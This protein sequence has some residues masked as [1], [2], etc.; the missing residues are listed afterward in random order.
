MLVPCP[1]I[2]LANYALT[3]V[4][5]CLVP[6]HNQDYIYANMSPVEDMMMMCF[7]CEGQLENQNTNFF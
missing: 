5:N 1:T 6:S 2:N 3:A 7:V 4:H